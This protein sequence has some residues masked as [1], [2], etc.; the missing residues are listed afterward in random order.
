MSIDLEEED[1][2]NEDEQIFDNFSLD[3]LP[4]V[5]YYQLVTLF[6]CDG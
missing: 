2:E 1:E 3:P 5:H 6:V 4:G